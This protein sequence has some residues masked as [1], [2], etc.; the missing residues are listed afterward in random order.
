M[1]STLERN[2]TQ[3]RKQTI[4]CIKYW[5]HEKFW[6]RQHSKYGVKISQTDKLAQG[7]L[8]ESCCQKKLK[9]KKNPQGLFKTI[10]NILN[11]CK[12][13]HLAKLVIHQFHHIVFLLDFQ[14]IGPLMNWGFAQQAAC[15]HWWRSPGSVGATP[16]PPPPRPHQVS[17]STAGYGVSSTQL[18]PWSPAMDPKFWSQWIP[19]EKTLLSCVDFYLQGVKEGYRL[20]ENKIVAP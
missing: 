12:C 15:S 6:S 11:S 3:M 14:Q 17:I 19:Q 9:K 16:H 13:H 20:G 1:W 18:C 5:E 8:K 4:I 7:Q 2:H 10:S